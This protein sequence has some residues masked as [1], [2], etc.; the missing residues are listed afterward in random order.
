MVPI[1]SKKNKVDWVDLSIKRKQTDGGITKNYSFNNLKGW[2]LNINPWS[3]DREV[4]DV[5]TKMNVKNKNEESQSTYYI[6]NQEIG[7]LEIK[8]G[9]ESKYLKNRILVN[10]ESRTF[11]DDIEIELK[12]LMGDGKIS[13]KTP[14]SSTFMDYKEPFDVKES[15]ILVVK[16]F[17]DNKPSSNYE[18]TFY[19]QKP[20]PAIDINNT[21]NG[22]K[23]KYYEGNWSKIPD[24]ENETV[25]KE[26]FIDDISSSVSNRKENYGLVLSGN[27]LVPDKNIYTFYLRSND[28]SRL[29]IGGKIVSEIDGKAGLDPIFAA[30]SRIALSKGFHSFEIEYFQSVTRNSLFVEIESSEIAKQVIPASMLFK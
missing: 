8:L 14:S 19:K 20:L 2:T 4:I 30:P 11:I 23:Y 24:F 16:V 27:I 6:N 10:P 22:L 15:G 17:E 5:I 12:S 1:S 7:S 13:Y 21:E 18:I 3:E 9:N 25:I 28:G 29:K 26:G